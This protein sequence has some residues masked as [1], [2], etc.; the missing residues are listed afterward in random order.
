MPAAIA[1]AVM[2]SSQATLESAPC[3]FT[4]VTLWP[5]HGRDR[6]QRADLV[7]DEVLDLGGL[8]PCDRMPAKAVQVAIAGMRADRDAARLRKLHRPAH[9]VGVAGME[10]A[11]DVDRACELDHGGVVAH[12]PR[13]KTFAEVAIQIDCFHGLLSASGLVVAYG[14]AVTC[15]VPASTA[16]TA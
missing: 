11:G 2:S 15:H 6:L 5:G 8:E 9:D 3:A 14:S 1:F 12:L 13:T 7:G 10:A 16:L 4:C